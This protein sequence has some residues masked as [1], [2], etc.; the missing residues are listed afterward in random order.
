MNIFALTFL[1]IAVFVS[2][3]SLQA[4]QPQEVQSG[5]RYHWRPDLPSVVLANELLEAFKQKL[6]VEW[7]KSRLNME[8]I[9]NGARQTVLSHAVRDSKYSSDF[10][11]F[12]R[13]HGVEDPVPA[14]VGPF[15][16]R[17][18]KNS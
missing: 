9:E 15:I 1:S 18:Q 6:P 4:M 11:E 5:R 16:S 10:I 2:S 17:S 3:L 7:Y 14:K 13:A 12:L 8:F